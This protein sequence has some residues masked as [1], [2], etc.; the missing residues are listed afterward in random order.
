VILNIP[1]RHALGI[2]S[3]DLIL[4]ASD[5]FLVL[6]YDGGLKFSRSVTWHAKRNLPM[7]RAHR[8][9]RMTIAAVSCRLRL[10]TILGVAKLCVKL[11]L[12]CLLKQPTEHVLQRMIDVPRRLDIVLLQDSSH[13]FF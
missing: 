9:L 13:L 2:Q 7:L 6:L 8:F 1:D 3:E 4:N 12:Q 11:R 10:L 5:L